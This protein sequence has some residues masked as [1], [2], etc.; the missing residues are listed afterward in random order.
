MLL[1]RIGRGVSVSLVIVAALA[2]G[3]A[4]VACGGSIEQPAQSSANASKAPVGTQ[5]H[6]IV[7]L[8]G[9]ALG[10]VALRNDQRTAIEALMTD[11][12]T[13]HAPILEHRRDLA[14]ALSDSIE[15]G[16][17]I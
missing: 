11:A 5:T 7:H 2:A 1:A 9:D 14:G 3:S 16:C 15:R 4:A 13:R 12:E 6:G 10:D 17:I 8:F